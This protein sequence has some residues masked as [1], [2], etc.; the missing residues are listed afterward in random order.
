MKKEQQDAFLSEEKTFRAKRAGCLLVLGFMVLEAVAVAAGTAYYLKNK[1][2]DKPT[3]P[4]KI[5][6]HNTISKQERSEH[7][8]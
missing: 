7:T 3:E 1:E 4:A 8:R 5:S 6:S 2:N